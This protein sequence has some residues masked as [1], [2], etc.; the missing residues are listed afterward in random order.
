MKI[1][2]DMLF[3]I[4]FS[5][6]FI[7]LFVTATVLKRKIHKK[8][9]LIASVIGGLYG[10]LEI[11]CSFK[12]IISAFLAITVS[13]LMCFVAYYE[14]NPKR[15][16]GI[17]ILYWG[18]GACLGGFM[19][20]FYSLLNRIL[21]DYIKNYSY[22]EVYTGAR[23]FIIS[24]LAILV[25]MVLGRL[26]NK[27]KNI[28]STRIDVVLNK[29]SFN[30]TALC[31]SGNLLTEP[32]SGKAVVLVSSETMLGKEIASSPDIRKR[33]IPYYGVENEGML[34][35]VVPE[36]ILI[37]GSEKTA[38]VASIENKNFAGYEACAPM[39]LVV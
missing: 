39:S 15:F 8:R 16:A 2:A 35:G 9:T 38:V 5:M 27:E 31:D 10:V 36:K 17:C 1:Y 21:A 13:V 20:L 18:V 29:K 12:P 7:S 28:K 23:F 24:A 4:N 6:D 33:Y 11:I 30:L 25:S 19:S 37:N 26:F 32:I 34:K 3:A 14:K 22:S